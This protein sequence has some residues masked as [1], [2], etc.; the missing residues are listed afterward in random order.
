MARLYHTG[1]EVGSNAMFDLGAGGTMSTSGTRGAWST[2]CLTG[3]SDA[4]PVVS[5]MA[6]G[7]ASELFCGIG[8][9]TT[10][11]VSWGRIIEFRTS[12]NTQQFCVSFN[13]GGHVVLFRGGN[14]G[15]ILGTGT[16]TMQT[17]RWTFVEF[18]I[19]MSDASG[20]FEC[21]VDGAVDGSL[22]LSS[23]DTKNH[24]SVSAVDRYAIGASNTSWDD[25]YVNDTTGSQNT[26][27]SGD[28]RIS[29]YVPNAAGDVAGMTPTSGANYTN[30]DERPPNDATDI[31]AATGTTL[32][33]L[34][35][36]PNT[37]GVATVQAVQLWLRAQKSDAGA[38]SIAHM[39]KSGSTENQGADAALSTSWAYYPKVYSND[40]T[41]SAAWTPSK[42]DSLQI[43]AKAR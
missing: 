27:Y 20:S 24:A 8:F 38:K 28:T 11:F 9:Y 6:G 39:L 14:G 18:H 35:N 12:D 33:D 1:F 16:I 32:Y 2:Y 25:L 29:A 43:G 13:S 7:S 30:V 22:T 41:D 42:L 17:N 4:G 34:Y 5:T 21:K 23:I 31:V 15:T 26:G 19:V 36:I 40:P 3:L 10:S 37:S